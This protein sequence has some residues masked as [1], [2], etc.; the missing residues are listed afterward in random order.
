M[1][2]LRQVN[3]GGNGAKMSCWPL[4]LVVKDLSLAMTLGD[5]LL[6]LSSDGDTHQGQLMMSVRP[7]SRQTPVSRAF[8]SPKI[9]WRATGAYGRTLTV[10]LQDSGLAN[11]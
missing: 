1:S 7:D 6:Q 11:L 2:L 9:Q 8:L 4:D 3:G 10:S 5:G